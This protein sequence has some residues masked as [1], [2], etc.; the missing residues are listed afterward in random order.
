MGGVAPPDGRCGHMISQ[1]VGQYGYDEFPPCNFGIGPI[2]NG[3]FLLDSTWKGRRN[4]GRGPICPSGVEPLV[5]CARRERSAIPSIANCMTCV[6]RPFW[7]WG[8]YSP[9][10]GRRTGNKLWDKRCRNRH[11][12]RNYGGGRY[13][14]SIYWLV[15]TCGGQSQFLAGS[16][17]VKTWTAFGGLVITGCVSGSTFALRP[18]ARGSF[19]GAYRDDVYGGVN[20]IGRANNIGGQGIAGLAALAQMFWGKN[21]RA[22]RSAPFAGQG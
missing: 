6:L 7:A 14:N 1:A 8:F 18:Y 19:S 20:P 12:F 16:P 22:V 11:R 4:V 3:L 17:V 21:L 2:F 5:N 13:L 10:S 9:R 15:W